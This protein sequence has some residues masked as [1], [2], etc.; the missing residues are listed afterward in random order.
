M[1]LIFNGNGSLLASGI[2][3]LSGASAVQ[4]NSGLAYSRPADNATRATISATG[5]R[6]FNSSGTYTIGWCGYFYAGWRTMAQI[7]T[8]G[9]IEV[10]NLG[11]KSISRR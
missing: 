6:V 1:T 11:D 7:D 9:W 5:T 4:F 3:C 8:Q 2:R 10:T